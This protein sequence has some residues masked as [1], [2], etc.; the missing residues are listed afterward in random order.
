M[1]FIYIRSHAIFY[2]ML[3]NKMKYRN[4]SNEATIQYIESN[5]GDSNEATCFKI[6]KAIIFVVS[7]GYF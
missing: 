6:L 7:S 5:N 4:R 1:I 2:N 3:L